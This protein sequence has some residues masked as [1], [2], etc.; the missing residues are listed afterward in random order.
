[1]KTSPGW[2]IGEEIILTFSH[3][4]ALRFKWRR[5]FFSL[6]LFFASMRKINRFMEILLRRDNG[7]IIVSDNRFFSKQLFSR[8]SAWNKGLQTVWSRSK[9]LMEVN[10]GRIWIRFVFNSFKFVFNELFVVRIWP[11]LSSEFGFGWIRITNLNQIW[12]SNQIWN[13]VW[14]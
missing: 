1:M 9:K 7:H 14:I 11:N 8:H 2:W 6:S 10:L 4:S 5:N 13:S 3:D 12:V